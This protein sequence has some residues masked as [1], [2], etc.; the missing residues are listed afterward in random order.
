LIAGH[1]S[2]V[3]TRRTGTVSS[4]AGN[5]IHLAAKFAAPPVG[6]T[7]KL[8]MHSFGSCTSKG[9]AMAKTKGIVIGS[10]IFGAN[11]QSWAM[12]LAR[13]TKN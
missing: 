6:L 1:L 8:T 11:R 13:A 7:I 5:F 12:F 3:V 10:E 2:P 9:S 4:D